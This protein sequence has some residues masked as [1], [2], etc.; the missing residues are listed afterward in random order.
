MRDIEQESSQCSEHDRERQYVQELELAARIGQSLLSENQDL[1]QKVKQ[2]ADSLAEAQLHAEGF[3]SKM[4]SMEKQRWELKNKL[5]ELEEEIADSRET[6]TVKHSNHVAI[7]TSIGIEKLDVGEDSGEI[8]ELRQRCEVA[9]TEIED[10]RRKLRSIEND[11]DDKLCEI[12]HMK[13]QLAKTASREDELAKVFGEQSNI[14]SELQAE[15][16]NSRKQL[17]GCKTE[18]DILTKQS[19]ELR[20][21]IT[22]KQLQKD[23]LVEQCRKIQMQTTML[24][25]NAGRYDKMDSVASVADEIKATQR[26]STQSASTNSLRGCERK[27]VKRKTVQEQMSEAHARRTAALAA[28]R[29]EVLHEKRTLLHLLVQILQTHRDLSLSSL[30]SKIKQ[31][32]GKGWGGHW[33]RK[34]GPLLEFLRQHPEMFHAHVR[35]GVQLRF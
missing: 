34:H 35:S 10:L 14:C 22:E 27:R 5:R 4:S 13:E 24:L 25:I 11:F 15:V 26:A 31:E 33:S 17:E 7:Q 30:S 32:T 3:A 16:E 8:E 21:I 19:F 2:M 29:K 9:D 20:E 12:I 1:K 18:N 23:A 6:P 28:S